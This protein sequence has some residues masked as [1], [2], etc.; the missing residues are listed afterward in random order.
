MCIVRIP[1]V[2]RNDRVARPVS[3]NSP[4]LAGNFTLRILH[5]HISPFCLLCIAFTL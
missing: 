5:M 4:G 2:R 3:A 1:D